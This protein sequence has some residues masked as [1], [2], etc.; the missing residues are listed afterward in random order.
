[1]TLVF[2]YHTLRYWFDDE[3]MKSHYPPV[4]FINDFAIL[5]SVCL[6]LLGLTYAKEAQDK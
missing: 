1:M 2:T 6:V 4:V 3:K 5:G